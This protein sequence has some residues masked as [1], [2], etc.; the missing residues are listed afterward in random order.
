MKSPASDHPYPPL[1]RESWMNLNGCWQFAHDP[2]GEGLTEA[3]WTRDRLPDAIEV[4][5]CVESPASG[6]GKKIG[7]DHLW[8]LRR[9]EI[10][11]DWLGRTIYLHIGAA[12]YICEGYVNGHH[13]GSHEGGYTPIRWRIDPQLRPG[14]NAICLHVKETREGK[15][16]RGKQTHLPFSYTIFYQPYSGVWQPVWLEACGATHLAQAH[17]LTVATGEAFEFHLRFDG[18]PTGELEIALTHPDGRADAFV[19]QKIDASSMIV[20]VTPQRP[21]HW[22]PQTPHLYGVTYR[23]KCN[24]RI[25]DEATGY[26]GL[27]TIVACDGKVLLNGE[28]LWQKLVLYQAYYPA[29]W[30]APTDPDMFRRD[31]ELIKSFGF[32]GLRIHQTLADPRLLYWCDR[33][34]LVVWD[35]MPSPFV[36]SRVDRIA[37]E[38]ML[39]E[40][41]ARDRGHPCVVSWVLFNE[42]WGILDI[43]W[44]EN[45][46]QWVRGMVR[47]CRELD[48]TRP[49]IDNSGYDHLD[50]DILDIHHY[51]GD[52]ERVRAYYRQLGDPAQIKYEAWRNAYMVRPNKIYK[53]PLAPTGHYRNQPVII[54]ECGGHGFGPYGGKGMTLEESV[55]Q[56]LSL[57]A[58]HEHLQGFCYTQLF[59]VQQERNGLTDFERKPKID[60]ARIRAI[61][62]QLFDK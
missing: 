23:I 2:R 26:A 11:A 56:V 30:A 61:L 14:E 4:P 37:F 42:T 21:A 18:E 15:L 29:G 49:V 13:V 16:P 12:D 31:V 46:R 39:R 57:I 9:V 22:S 36:F 47:L 25:I 28:P 8:Y 60:P 34:G 27:R 51:L 35:E 48:P 41:V 54:S 43:V 59:D 55:R 3:W 52:P 17:P 24:R 7:P 62:E 1:Q 40:A 5:F 44:N 58:E 19:R 45:T 38:R 10:P 6:I 50:T 53:S 32:N 33:L 20:R